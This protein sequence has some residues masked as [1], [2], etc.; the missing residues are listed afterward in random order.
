MSQKI[1]DLLERKYLG[2]FNISTIDKAQR[3]KD[4]PLLQ[5]FR[6]VKKIGNSKIDIKS[7]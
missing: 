1:L 6:M 4:I 2:L 5:L 7:M 3:I